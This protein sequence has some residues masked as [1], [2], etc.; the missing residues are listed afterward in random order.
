[1]ARKRARPAG[2]PPPLAPAEYRK[3]YL[4]AVSASIGLRA[5]AEKLFYPVPPAAAAA[6]PLTPADRELLS[7]VGLPRR[8]SMSGFYG[9]I[10]A[11]DPARGLLKPLAEV[12]RPRRA[13]PEWA[14]QLVLAEVGPPPDKNG[15]PP[16]PA[17]SYVCLNSADAAVW[18]VQ[19]AGKSQTFVNSG[20]SAYAACLCRMRQFGTAIRNVVE[21]TLK[22]DGGF[23]ERKATAVAEKCRADLPAIDRACA[24]P[25]AFWPRVIQAELGYWLPGSKVP[26]VGK[27][28]TTRPRRPKGKPRAL[29]ALLPELIDASSDYFTGPRL[30]DRMIRAA[31]RKLGY[32]LPKSYL[33]LLRLKNG[34]SLA[35]ECFPTK[36]RT[37]WA[38]DHVQI[39]GIYGIG[40]EHG[41]D[42]PRGGSRYMIDEWGYPD[43]GVVIGA[44]PSGGHTTVMLDYSRCG[45][46]GEPRVIWVEAAEVEGERNRVLVLAKDFET[47]LRGLR[48]CDEF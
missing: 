46:R 14:N 40:G 35:R 24:D 19:I 30:T 25:A 27:P 18:F 29:A 37:S 42:A 26:P 31:E 17:P 33:R 20:L 43:V 15:P 28:R 34:A 3:A 36:A 44:T 6:A 21:R 38:D 2:R 41:I 10:Q 9:V 4:R 45:P 7:K 12:C 32:R 16:A 22:P 48:D 1:M 47:F 8:F 11:A 23:D 13:R 39:N 5:D